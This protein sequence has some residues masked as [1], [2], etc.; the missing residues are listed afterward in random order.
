MLIRK[1]DICK[2]EIGEKDCYYNIFGA[3]EKSDRDMMY[4]KDFDKE[5][6][7]TC[8]QNML[9]FFK[10]EVENETEMDSK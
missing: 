7:N 10:I 9:D 5:L 4:K 8:Y 6:C 1:C 3:K 2:E